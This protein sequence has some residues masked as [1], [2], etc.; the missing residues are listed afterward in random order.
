MRLSSKSSLSY[1]LLTERPDG[2]GLEAS[3]VGLRLRI[4]SPWSEMVHCVAIPAGITHALGIFMKS[5]LR[6]GIIQPFSTSLVYD[7]RR[8][9]RLAGVLAEPLLP[10][11]MAAWI[12]SSLESSEYV[13]SFLKEY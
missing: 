1:L 13:I 2:P 3:W 4:L 10:H 5:S 12:S 8:A 6:K 11:L 7:F 9:E